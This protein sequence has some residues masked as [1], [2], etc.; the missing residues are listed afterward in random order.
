MIDR[1]APPTGPK[2]DGWHTYHVCDGQVREITFSTKGASSFAVCVF[3]GQTQVSDVTGPRPP[4][5]VDRPSFRLGVN[6]AGIDH[7]AKRAPC[8]DPDCPARSWIRYAQTPEQIEVAEE[9]DRL[10][11]PMDPAQ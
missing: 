2:P 6:H 4:L 10:G 9:L 5:R 1:P 11:Y 3:C 7:D 8:G